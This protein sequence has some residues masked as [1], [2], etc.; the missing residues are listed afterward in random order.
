MGNVPDH[1]PE[2]R[3]RQGKQEKSEREGKRKNQP[4]GGRVAP[5]IMPSAT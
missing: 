3:I 1:I 5:A 4:Q 2:E